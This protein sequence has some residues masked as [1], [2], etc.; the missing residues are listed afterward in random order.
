MRVFG[1]VGDNP[2]I[3][4]TQELESILAAAGVDTSTLNTITTPL[5]GASRWA[6]GHFLL[7]SVEGLRPINF[8]DLKDQSIRVKVVIWEEGVTSTDTGQSFANPSTG[9]ALP[10]P[11]YIGYSGP[12][13]ADIVANESG[14]GRGQRRS[15]LTAPV[16]SGVSGRGSFVEPVE[17][18][19]SAGGSS[20]VLRSVSRHGVTGASRQHGSGDGQQKS[21]PDPQDDK[22][23]RYAAWKDM[24]V[25]SVRAVNES[26]ID[27]ATGTK[28]DGEHDALYV[29]TV[30][31]GRYAL[32]KHTGIWSNASTSGSRT[33]DCINTPADCPIFFR[34]ETISLSERLE[35]SLSDECYTSPARGVEAS[36]FVGMPHPSAWH[37]QTPYT[38]KEV[39]DA[40]AWSIISSQRVHSK[41][42]LSLDLLPEDWV[43]SD[44][45]DI[46]YR[47]VAT[48]L[49]LDDLAS[50]VGCVWLWDRRKA[51]LVL[52]PVHEGWW[53]GFVNDFQSLNWPYRTSGGFNSSGNTCPTT[54]CTSHPSRWLS[55]VGDFSGAVSKC[56]IDYSSYESSD[57]IRSS[58]D[59]SQSAIAPNYIM[60]A[61]DSSK[62]QAPL[63][64]TVP[65]R[66][67]ALFGFVSLSPGEVVTHRPAW[68]TYNDPWNKTFSSTSGSAWGG[69]KSADNIEN[70]NAIIADRVNQIRSSVDGD[71]T[72]SR[73]PAQTG[74]D[75]NTKLLHM[76]PSIGI[77]Y[78]R[79]TVGASESHSVVYR[80][81][82]ST[83]DPILYPSGTIFQS[84]E[85]GMSSP[86]AWPARRMYQRRTGILRSFLCHFAA[87]R[88]AGLL[89]TGGS[90]KPNMWLYE[91]V[92]ITMREVHEFTFDYFDA[93]GDLG[94]HA[95]ALNMCELQ[96]NA[97]DTD[98]RNFD[99]GELNYSPT[100]EED[101]VVRTSPRGVCVAYEVAALNGFPS[102]Y[103]FAPNGVDIV[104]GEPPPD[105]KLTDGW[106]RT[107]ITGV[108]F[109]TTRTI[110][111]IIGEP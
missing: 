45:R 76:T 13:N 82:G 79:F 22:R 89:T 31:D 95:F 7:A 107:G 103:I 93:G 100:G 48:G 98:D 65:D 109:P 29:V 111:S 64:I 42:S 16:V 91:I 27:I 94:V 105:P 99:G 51:M 57:G 40:A 81:W 19:A 73:I 96:K 77:Q 37:T 70:R 21:V 90:E 35:P 56:Y 11:Q 106:K 108:A 59:P 60:Q 84:A 1:H 86:A 46:D 104:C 6:T 85:S 88:G 49:C 75:G 18:V 34:A 20:G 39:F 66:L 8:Y 43:T 28:P 10:E 24:I 2:V 71:I 53:M 83:S 47:G 30:V 62:L 12:V 14:D 36:D 61:T 25:T 110:S 102:Y 17:A 101:E 41:I 44:M 63:S 55:M 92:E 69:E 15:G 26:S 5:I 74:A 9:A 50:R 32:S 78:D 68:L 33:S 67:P 52:F 80:A 58:S 54:V 38:V 72:L 97:V 3:S 4:L 23:E 87:T